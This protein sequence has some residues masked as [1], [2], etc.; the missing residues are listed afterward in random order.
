MRTQSGFTLIELMVVVTIIGIL[1]AIAI[2]QFSVYKDRAYR[3]E[4]HRLGGAMREEVSAY[5]D[6]VGAL[7]KHND[8]LGLPEPGAIRGKYVSALGIDNGTVT[9][10]FDPKIKSVIAGKTLQ[11][12][13]HINTQ[14]PTGPLVWEWIDPPKEENTTQKD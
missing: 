8:A 3:G 6:T 11:L 9:M 1:A 4:G 13:P 7:P 10:R 5:Y 14:Y 12:V 2:P